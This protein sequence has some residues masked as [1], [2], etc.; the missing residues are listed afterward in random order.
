MRHAGAALHECQIDFFNLALG[1]LLRKRMV[2]GIGLCNDEA[3]A[4][5]LVEPVNDSRALD[6]TDNGDSSAVVE[7]GVDNRPIG[8]ARARVYDEPGRLVRTRE[9]VGIRKPRKRSN[10]PPAS[11]SSTKNSS[12][13][14][15]AFGL[16]RAV[17][18]D[19]DRS[20]VH[21][22]PAKHVGK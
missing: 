15:R 16:P 18:Y 11:A 12:G 7:Q 4:G 2:G 1:K 6:P 5:L 19:I 14:I 8:I 9:N 21:P 22:T 3:S 13:I 17:A 10:R 20:F